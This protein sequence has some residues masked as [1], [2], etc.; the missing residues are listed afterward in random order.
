[1]QFVPLISLIG[2][3]LA[4][5]GVNKSMDSTPV[6][7]DSLVKA[8]M[9]I[10]L[11]VFVLTILLTIYLFFTLSFSLRKFQKKLFIAIALS[12]PFYTV[13]LIYSAIGDFSTLKDFG[14]EGNTTIYLCMSVLEEII[15]MII[16]VT[17]GILAVLED[18]FPNRKTA[19]SQEDYLV[20]ESQY[21]RSPNANG[22]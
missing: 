15:A 9:G 1:M 5:V 22:M 20:K 17:F 12:A 14:I 8:A 2:L 3:I 11:A 4:I 7:L 18:D 16:V 13:R 21:S 6:Q 19:I 10:F